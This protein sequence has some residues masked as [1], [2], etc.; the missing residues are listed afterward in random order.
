MLTSLGVIAVTGQ[1]SETFLQ[2]QIT[3]DIRTLTADKASSAALC[4]I[5]GRMQSTFILI[6]QDRFYLIVPLNNL[7]N[8]VKRLKKYAL[9]SKVT[10]SDVSAEWYFAAVEAPSQKPG[11]LFTLSQEAPLVSSITLPGHYKRLL[12]L[13]TDQTALAAAVDAKVK[14][15]F[16]AQGEDDWQLANINA[17]WAL[18]LPETA[19]LFTPQMIA[20]EKQGGVSF[21][22]GCYLGQE[23]IAR[24]EH[25]GKLKRHLYLVELQRGVAA[26]P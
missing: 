6:K 25:L 2:G 11:E 26:K 13:C 20:L 5:E 17:R 24:T 7:A 23:I 4:D 19:E 21:K 22:K 3:A 8:T 10:L 18:I 15:G 1:D 12:L 9:F 14:A 16:T